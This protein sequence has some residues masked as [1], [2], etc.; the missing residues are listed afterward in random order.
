MGCARSGSTLTGILLGNNISILDVGEL[1][2]FPK[3]RGKPNGYGI[4]T[5]NFHFWEKVKKYP[6]KTKETNYSELYSIS[7]K[8]ESNKNFFL[9]YF[10]FTHSKLVKA[11]KKYINDIFDSIFEISGKS[12]I[13]DS[14]KY[15][16]RALALLKYL[17]KDIHIIYL[18]RNP[19][20]VVE[21]FS[22]KDTM[23]GT[24]NF[25]VANAYYFYINL[26]CVLTV[27]KAGKTRC[28]KVKYENLVLNTEEEL[29]RIQSICNIDLSQSVKMIKD[30]EPFKSEF[31]FNGNRMRLDKE[32]R[33]KAN[34]VKHKRSIKNKF[35]IF[36]N[37]IWY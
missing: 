18:V 11:Y 4:D 26:I 30:N 20:G 36:C 12:V 5:A 25:F 3:L 32:I 14:S 7:K 37:G 16:G 15:A 1:V 21:S 10:N 33:V 35:I 29:K 23:Q 9:N 34:W 28:I 27:L 31:I 2:D 22:K 24:L 8:I 13:I 19:I 17:D 6:P